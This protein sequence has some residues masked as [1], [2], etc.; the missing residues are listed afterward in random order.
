MGDAQPVLPHVLDVLGPGIDKGDVLPRLH[1][2]RPGISADGAS[3][4][5]C[6]LPSHVSL[7]AFLAADDRP[8]RS[9]VG[10][11]LADRGILPTARFRAKHCPRQ[12]RFEP[13][14]TLRNFIHE[15]HG[16]G[17]RLLAG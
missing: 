12:P 17:P 8:R 11:S 1:H 14:W 5:D 10:D 15:Q 7:P 6:D 13:T 4:D 16:Y 3:S 9:F 2:V